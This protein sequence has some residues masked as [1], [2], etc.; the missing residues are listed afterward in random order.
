[1]A[2]SRVLVSRVRVSR[3]RVSRVRVSRVRVSRVRVSRVRVSRARG[4]RTDSEPSGSNQSASNQSGSNQSGSNQSGSNQSGTGG[5]GDDGE[6][7]NRRRRRRGRGR[8]RDEIIDP[9]TSDPIE[10]A[11]YLDLRDDGYGFLRVEGPLPSNDD[12]YVPVKMVRQF[13]LR[14]GDLVSG[15]AR[16]ANRNEKNPALAEVASINERTPDDIGDRPEFAKLTPVF[17]GERLRLER[18]DDP[19]SITPGPSTSSLLW[20]RASGCCS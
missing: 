3:V 1:M 17:P 6:S 7:G 13:D 4:G 16:P 20:A 10:V 14:K 5:N 2:V 18:A 12:V 15:T 8:D 9:V 19:G 11:G